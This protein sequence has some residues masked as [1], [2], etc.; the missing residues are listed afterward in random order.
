MGVSLIRPTGT[1]YFVVPSNVTRFAVVTAGAGTAET[2]KATIR[3]AA[4]NVAA[5]KDNIAAPHVFVL[6]PDSRGVTEIWSVTF[7]KASEGVLEDVSVQTVG[8]PPLFGAD[9]GD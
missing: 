9:S 4:G 6:E 7:E 3:D 8:I 5:E 2:V 1:L